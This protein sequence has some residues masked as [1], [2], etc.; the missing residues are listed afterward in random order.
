[1]ANKV[2]EIPGR[3]IL[4]HD[5]ESNWNRAE[6]FIPK[7]G[8]IIIYDID[9]NHSYERFK[10]GDG[11]SYVNAL[12]FYNDGFVSFQEQYLTDEQKA[13]V[14]ENIGVDDAVKE[15]A[16]SKFYVVTFDQGSDGEYHGDLTF[17][18]IRE[19]F[20]AGGNMVARIDGTDYIPLLS[21]AEHQIIFSG[22]YQA[23]SVSLTVDK[24]D[25]CTLTSTSLSRSNHSHPTASS[26]TSGFMSKADKSKLDGI[27]TGAEVNVIESIVVNGEEVTVTDKTVNIEIP[28]Q[29][30]ADWTQTDETALDFIKNKP[31]L[32]TSEEI[33][34][35]FN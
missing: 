10:I 14:R 31:I 18:E 5:I 16:D 27:E 3:L 8:E 4:K 11:A 29:I 25:V 28:E 33:K 2:K 30:K 9:D 15:A 1:M 26:S 35:L 24:N 34:A 13:Q 22:I 6:T 17:A 21:A 32:V 23:T 19:K 20:E 7:Q 12:P